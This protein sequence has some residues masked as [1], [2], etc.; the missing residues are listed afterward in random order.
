MSEPPNAEGWTFTRAAVARR[1]LLYVG[2]T[3]D[4]LSTDDM[5]GSVVFRVGDDLQFFDL[6]FTASHLA[7]V[8]ETRPELL[9]VSN[10]GEARAIRPGGFADETIR[11]GEK[12]PAE[13]GVIRGL[14]VIAGEVWAVGMDRQ[15]YRRRGFNAWEAVEDGLPKPRGLY[16]VAGLNSIDGVSPADLISVGW[17]GEI[18]WWDGQSWSP[19]AVSTNLKLEQVI[20]KTPDDIV[21]GGQRGVVLRGTRNR[22]HVVANDA[23]EAGVTGLAVFRNTVW[24]ATLFGLYRFNDK[25]EIARVDVGIDDPT[26]QSFGWL[27]ACP[28]QIWSI[29]R[30]RLLYSDDGI[31]WSERPLA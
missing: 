11:A 27:S 9:C 24:L 23:F 2:A 8:D 14:R 13:R 15:V 30:K 18:W 26:G 1:N 4:A 28:E 21:I 12:T 25:G 17:G 10:A 29:G 31:A 7:Y 5:P 3:P 19:D 6:P 22:W 20:L 16:D